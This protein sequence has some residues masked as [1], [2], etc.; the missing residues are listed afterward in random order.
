[1]STWSGAELRSHA[2]VSIPEEVIGIVL[3]KTIPKHPDVQSV[4]PKDSRPGDVPV[5]GWFCVDFCLLFL[6]NGEGS[7]YSDRSCYDLILIVRRR[8]TVPGVMVPHLLVVRQKSVLEGKNED[9]LKKVL[10]SGLSATYLEPNGARGFGFVSASCSSRVKAEVGATISWSSVVPD[11]L[12][13]VE[14]KI[15]SDRSVFRP[16]HSTM[17][18][19][20]NPKVCSYFWCSRHVD[21]AC[22]LTR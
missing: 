6:R 5:S 16:P 12:I 8:D 2:P 4:K 19:N 10:R 18:P 13:V 3:V 17:P 9:R 11:S 7:L 20:P 14:G 1:M 22:R 21:E 15:K